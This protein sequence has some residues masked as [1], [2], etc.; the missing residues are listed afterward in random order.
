MTLSHFSKIMFFGFILMCLGKSFSAELIDF[1]ERKTRKSPA[2]VSKPKETKTPSYVLKFRETIDTLSC[3][4]RSKLRQ[5]MLD[6]MDTTK[7]KET[8][9]YYEVLILELTDSIR[10]R[11]CGKE[12]E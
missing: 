8:L 10:S 5:K 9:S 12:D 11:D 2:P 6:K 7:S 3:E 1:G 4:A